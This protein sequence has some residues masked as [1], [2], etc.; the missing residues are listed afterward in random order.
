ML[1]RERLLLVAHDRQLHRLAV[2]R[3]ES[4]LRSLE[5]E[6]GPLDESLLGEIE[7]AQK[8][9]I[10][11]DDATYIVI[12]DWQD[13]TVDLVREYGSFPSD[14]LVGWR[15]GQ[16]ILDYKTELAREPLPAVELPD[17]PRTARPLRPVDSDPR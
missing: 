9:H 3:I 15:V 4:A 8:L 17:A 11:G 14:A 13:G 2:A 6:L 16:S 5:A 1:L 7:L 12:G 10:Q